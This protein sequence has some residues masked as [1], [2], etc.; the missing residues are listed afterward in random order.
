M[1]DPEMAE[2]MLDPNPPVV[3]NLHE[4]V[5]DHDLLGHRCSTTIDGPPGKVLLDPRRR[6]FVGPKHAR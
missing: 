6:L 4:V 5:P 2:V 1:L 3:T